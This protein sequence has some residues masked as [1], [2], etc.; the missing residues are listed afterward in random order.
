MQLKHHSVSVLQYPNIMLPWEEKANLAYSSRLYS[1]PIQGR[2]GRSSRK[3]PASRSITDSQERTHAHVLNVHSSL[4]SPWVGGAHSAHL[5]GG[6]FHL[7]KPSSDRPYKKSPGQGA[8]STSL[9]DCFLVILDW[10]K[11]TR[12]TVTG[13]KLLKPHGRTQ[14]SGKFS[15]RLQ[16]MIFLDIV[17]AF[18]GWKVL[19]L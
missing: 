1:P 13:E 5:Q 10:V 2:Q 14:T 11:R 17:Y 7:Y 18:E 15:L 16:E 12:L 3:L 8:P 9:R 4:H 6:S 19:S